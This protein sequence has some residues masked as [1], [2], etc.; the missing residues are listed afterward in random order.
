MLR[1]LLCVL[2][3]ALTF[4]CSRPPGAPIPQSVAGSPDE[5]KAA[6]VPATQADMMGP[7]FAAADEEFTI[8]ADRFKDIQ[9]LRYQIPGFEGLTLKQKELLYHLSEAALSG[10]D[11][12]WY[13]TAHQEE[14]GPKTRRLR[15]GFINWSQVHAGEDVSAERSPPI[16]IE[17]DGMLLFPKYPVGTPLP[18]HLFHLVVPLDAHPDSLWG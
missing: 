1:H 14:W 7:G 3:L 16:P 11:I 13:Q 2:P 15:K 18:S 4:A 10:R 17:R 9:L 12:T 8:I 6:V 5:P